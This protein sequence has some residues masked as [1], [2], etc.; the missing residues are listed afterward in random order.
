MF[1]KYGYKYGGR[2]NWQS[3]NQNSG[4]YATKAYDDGSWSSLSTSDTS[5]GHPAKSGGVFGDAF[6]LYVFYE[7]AG[8]FK[9]ANR[10]LAR[11]YKKH[12]KSQSQKAF[13]SEDL[14]WQNEKSAKDLESELED[15]YFE[16]D[17]DADR[18]A[19]EV[20]IAELEKDKNNRAAL[21]AALTLYSKM[22]AIDKAIAEGRLQR[23]S[24]L[25]LSTI[26]SAGR[27]IV[28][29]Q[30]ALEELTHS[31][32]ADDLLEEYRD[33]SDV[34][35][36]YAGNLLFYDKHT[37]IW[38]NKPL[39]EIKVLVGRR[40]REQNN[41]K[42]ETDYAGITKLIYYSVENQDYF[43]KADVGICSKEGFWKVRGKEVI[44]V[45]HS[46]D[47][48][49]RFYLEVEP[50]FSDTPKLLLR[51][52]AE[53]FVQARPSGSETSQEQWDKEQS[54]LTKEQ[55]RLVQQLFGAT[56]LGI[57]P[58]LQIAV[59][60]YGAAGSFKSG[61]LRILQSLFPSESVTVVAPYELDQDYKKAVLAN[62]RLNVVPELDP[63][64]AIPS[65]EFK[66]ALGEDLLS[67]RLPYGIPFQFRSEAANWYNGNAF[68]ATKDH[69]E[70]FY[71]RWVII[72]FKTT[73]PAKERDPLLVAKII[74]DELA[75]IVAWAIDGARDLL[76]NGLAL[77]QDHHIQLNHW[78]LEANPVASWLADDE[79]DSGI[80]IRDPNDKASRPISRSDAFN[81]FKTWCRNSNRSIFTKTKWIAELSRLGHTAVKRGG[82]FVYPDLVTVAQIRSVREY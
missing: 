80:S 14:N 60:L 20:E 11:R 3:P 50:D 81:R 57:I 64:K 68:P 7:C 63:D 39:N 15:Q 72:H 26:R 67:A 54:E 24:G 49:A 69:G 43:L 42:R 2:G 71:R 31:E 30:S 21:N 45:K 58:R 12:D 61:T 40:F 35:T 48:A 22:S 73:K 66:S 77:S 75:K 29:S 46:K 52:L 47:N 55:V 19:F 51:V 10:D 74:D 25:S 34:P 53:A 44:L 38:R 4:S 23:A 5:I 82:N 27:E 76:A 37:G 36:G 41:A 16:T 56:L 9:V 32:M 18:E 28:K 13:F 1:E 79:G 65:A 62:K 6:D 70:A 33:K 59:F 17:E 8:D 78:K